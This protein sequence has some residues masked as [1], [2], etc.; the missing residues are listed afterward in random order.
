M[1][2]VHAKLQSLVESIT[3]LHPTVDRLSKCFHQDIDAQGDSNF[4]KDSANDWR[5]NIYGNAL[6][7]L[8]LILE[9]NF[10]VIET[11]GLVAVTRYI[12]ELTLWLELIQGDVNYALIYRRRLIDTQKRYYESSLKQFEREVALLKAFGEEDGQSTDAAIKKLFALSNPTSEEVSSILGQ[13][14][15]ETDA[16]AAR[17][18]SIFSDQAKTNGYGFQA[19]LVETHEIPKVKQ[20]IQ[21]LQE[22]LDEFDR[23]ASSK[24]SGLLQCSKWD[25]MAEEANM[26]A[27]YEYIY[28][29]TSKLLHCSPASITTNQKNLEPEEVVVFLRYVHTKIRDVIDLALKQP[30]CRIRIE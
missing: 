10:R 17:S 25:K 27:E 21:R 23:R 24:V 29:C 16:K 1:A 9:N 30:E 15:D 19:H 7:R 5:A 6:I 28:S 3:Q 8:R 18:F 26:T 4:D 14:S 20:H 11:I 12:F 13:A 22:E 2:P